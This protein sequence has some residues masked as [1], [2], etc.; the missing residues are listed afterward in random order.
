VTTR[1]ILIDDHAVVR[2]A[3][4]RVLEAHE[5]LQVVGTAED[6][7]SGIKLAQKENPDLILLD[8]ALPDADGLDLIPA[9]LR[10]CPD[11]RVLVL[12]MHSEPEYTAAA[13]ERGACGLVS[14]AESPEAFIDAVR[15][16][17]SGQNLPAA[18]PL[19]QRERDVLGQLAKGKAVEDIADTLGLK[20]KTVEGY[21]QQLMDRFD[22]HTR[23]GLVGYARRLGF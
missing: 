12:S 11:A 20:P 3:L 2:E 22:I 19:T 21:C 14:K 15:Q 1:L 9:F 18:S 17:S 7:A 10:H 5:D 4:T 6:G 8:I 16:V 23:V 13:V